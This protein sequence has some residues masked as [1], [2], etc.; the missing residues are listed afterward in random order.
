MK[1]SILIAAYR[2]GRYIGKAL[3]S[4]RAQACADWEIVVVEDGSNDETESITRAFAASVSQTVRYEN[5]G[6]NRGVAAARNRLL[7][8][9]RGDVLAFL[10]ADDWWTPNHLDAVSTTLAG[11][12]DVAIAGIQIFNLDAEEPLEAYSPPARLF[13]NPVRTLFDRSVVMTCTSV[14]LR[15]GIVERVGGFDPAFRIGEDRD[16]WL[17]CAL[18]GGLF[19]HSASVSCYYAKH[20]SSTMMKTLLWAQQEVAFY[21]KYQDL[22]AAPARLRRRRLSETLLSYGRLTRASDSSSSSR[23]LWRAWK[24]T[25]L[26]LAILP[27]LLFSLG[28]GFHCQFRTR[29]VAPQPVSQ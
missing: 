17:R 15:R 14:A 10:D 26:R 6:E 19:A 9:A 12:A 11:G 18:A 21:E 24:L 25:P 28:K 20:A 23:A 13:A 22:A 16:Y 27:Q 2:A 5:L 4:V 3:E 7:Q 29:Q 1:F 8:L